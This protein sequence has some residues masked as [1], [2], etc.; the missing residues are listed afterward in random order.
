MQIRLAGN[1]RTIRD[2]GRWKD[3]EGGHDAEELVSDIKKMYASTDSDWVPR[4]DPPNQKTKTK[5][6]KVHKPTK[7]PTVYGGPHRPSDAEALSNPPDA[8]GAPLPPPPPP[9]PPEEASPVED[10]PPL[11]EDA[12]PIDV[13]AEPPA[14]EAAVPTETT[15]PPESLTGIIA[16]PTEMLTAFESPETTTVPD[17]ADF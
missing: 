16:T 5:T 2:G 10:G 15:I 6:A 4:R 12:Q 11:G 7:I 1:V 8:A 13:A 9:P 17:V 14:G 3:Y